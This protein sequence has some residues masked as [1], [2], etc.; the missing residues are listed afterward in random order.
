MRISKDGDIRKQEFLDTAFELFCKKG[1]ENTSINNIID[2]IGVSKGAFYYYFKS[3]E[4]VLDQLSLQQTKKLINNIKKIVE[5]DQ[6]N[7]L[8]KLN[9]ITANSLKYKAE[10]REHRK[11]I[12]KI[13][14]QVTNAKLQ[15]RILKNNVEYI[16]PIIQSII[17][18]GIQEGFFNT[19]FPEETAEIYIYLGYI[20]R[21]MLNRHL[22][23]IEKE[24]ENIEI[25][26]KKLLFYE[27][28]IERIFGVKNGSVKITKT[29]KKY[30]IGNK[31]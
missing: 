5:D 13:F 14:E 27:N 16:Q 23:K 25:I 6:L 3:K 8:E 9:Q 24:P 4:E 28:L 31:G 2:K 20:L 17:E 7:A 22:E 19:S 29:L 1:Y 12:Y 15:Q 30:F 18:Q 11:K 26:K 10:H 21:N